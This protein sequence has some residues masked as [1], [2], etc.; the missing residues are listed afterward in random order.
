MID[1]ELKNSITP[2]SRGPKR[3]G[4]QS[5]M[6]KWNIIKLGCVNNIPW[7]IDILFRFF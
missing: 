2:Y 4:A 6:P 1:N 3:R 5:T 7:Y